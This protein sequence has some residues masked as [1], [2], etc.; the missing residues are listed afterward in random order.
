MKTVRQ[1]EDF[2]V[3]LRLLEN[4]VAVDLSAVT[5]ILAGLVQSN[6]IKNKYSSTVKEGYGMLEVKAGSTDTI[7][8]KVL[9]ADSKLFDLGN[10]NVDVLVEFPD[11]VLTVR[12]KEFQFV[13]EIKVES[14]VLKDL[15][16]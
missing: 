8:I 3:E 15:T 12:R 4:S 10:M 1:G 14:G 13:N 11:D 9:R 6:V 16:I 2:I 7:L 5:N